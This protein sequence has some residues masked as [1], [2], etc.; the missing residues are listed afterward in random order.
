MSEAIRKSGRL[1][2]VVAGALIACAGAVFLTWYWNGTRSSSAKIRRDQAAYVDASVCATCHSEIASTFKKTGMGRS[3]YRPTSSNIIED[4]SKANTY[5]HQASGLSYRMVERDGKFYQRRFMLEDGKEV[6]VVEK[7]VD[8]ILGSGNHARTYL[9]RTPQGRLVELPVSWY[10]ERS[11]YWNMSPGFDRPDQ[12]DMHGPIG[13]ECMFCH[14][15][16][17]KA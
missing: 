16:Y 5:N 1:W 4:Y 12:P 14:N 17:L 10:V 2:M 8:Y 7:Q 3:F 9:H 11:G 15:A 13:P 6:N